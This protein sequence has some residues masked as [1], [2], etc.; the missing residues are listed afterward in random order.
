M[1]GAVGSGGV[2]GSGTAVAV[3]SAISSSTSATAVVG[4]TVLAVSLPP[5]ATNNNKQTIET[6]ITC[7]MILPPLVRYG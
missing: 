3:G 4:C 2:V 7:F 5:Q 1:G 6:R